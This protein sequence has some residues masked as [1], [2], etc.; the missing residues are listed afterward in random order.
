MLPVRAVKHLMN[1]LKKNLE[2]FTVL[3]GDVKES[4]LKFHMCPLKNAN[5]LKRWIVAIRRDG[6]T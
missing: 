5:L 1:S 3:D 4:G 2:K 6:F